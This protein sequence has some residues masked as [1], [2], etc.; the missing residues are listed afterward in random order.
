[1]K[2]RRRIG[3]VST[4]Y[5]VWNAD[6]TLDY[7]AMLRNMEVECA[8]CA[9]IAEC[10]HMWIAPL[11]NSV[12]LEHHINLSPKDYIERDLTVLARL[13]PNYDFIYMNAGWEETDA[14]PESEGCRMEFDAAM[15]RGL[16]HVVGAQGE[17]AVRQYLLEL[18]GLA[19]IE[20]TT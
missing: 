12:M 10:G 18:A 15:E 20:A 5:R 16:I 17:A 3:Y 19:N 4:R 13:W 11:H 8:A 1:M 14:V 7:Q 2:M 9:L 6:G